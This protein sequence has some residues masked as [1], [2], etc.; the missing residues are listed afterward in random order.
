MH[1][2]EEIAK[3]L[4]VAPCP[5]CGRKNPDDARFCGGC[6]AAR[7]PEFQTGPGV[8]LATDVVADPLLGR[9]IAD[10]YR[11]HALL[12]RG[13]M[14]VV[15]KVE[16]IHI[17]KLMAMKLLHGEL[18]R[19]ATTLKRFRREA[20]AASRLSHPNTVQV[21]D[22]GRS[23]GLVYLV[24]EL[25]E[26]DDWGALLRRHG[27]M[28]F[29][30]VARLV[31]QICGSVQAAHDAGI[32]HRDLKPEN[33]MITQ[34]AEGERA[35]VLDFG[36]AKL[37]D[38]NLGQ[39]VT[40][41]GAIVGTPYYMS[42]E[43]IRGDEVDARGDVYALG[44]IIYRAVT[45]VPPFT[46][47][48]PIA[49]L[50]KHITEDVV[51]PSRRSPRPMPDVVDEICLKA[52]EKDADDRYQSA[53]ALRQAL[54]D[55][56]ASQG[57]TIDPSYRSGVA[58][59]AL[60]SRAATREDVDSFEGRLR[61]KSRVLTALGLLAMLACVIAAYNAYRRWSDAPRVKTVEHEPND[62]IATAHVLPPDVWVWA[63]LGRRR[64]RSEGDIDVFALERPRA[65]A[66]I[67][68]RLEPLPN[69]DMMVELFRVGDSTPVLTLDAGG[70]GEVESVAAFP[71]GEDDYVLQVRE[72][73]RDGVM[74]IENISDRYRIR[75]SRV[76]LSSSSEVEVN[77]GFERATPILVGAPREGVIG[78]VSDRDT[79]CVE[80][81]APT[82][83]VTVALSAVPSL[84]LALVVM[85]RAND[86]R[87]E[88]DE[89]FEGEGET[90][91]VPVIAPMLTCFEVARSTRVGGA[92]AD[93][94]ARYRLLLVPDVRP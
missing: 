90:T 62:D 59:P 54:G 80:A 50:T 33:V 31:A 29:S 7:R 43:Q 70:V 87:R 86:T 57:E 8:E 21:F 53:S 65:A 94:S 79:Y 15:Y 38:T 63:A 10:R 55:Y 88:V 68:V 58:L 17:G 11:I 81:G 37:R 82:G 12:G 20:E 49:V 6:G 52:L 85:D 34:T 66:Q 92:Q 25:V 89:R 74:P 48:S 67:A 36:L 61:R 69:V 40:R 39:T 30:R 93:S 44:A 22:F 72:H 19:D 16:H 84:D 73:W 45:G 51:P 27:P 42:P 77:D 28:D 75:F 56:L 3:T 14:G 18:A 5:L 47:D 91:Q 26:G 24:M 2:G 71:V 23:E 9:V 78:W 64:N 35:K 76:V 1:A 41:A 4:N 83:G 60:K 32:V 46:A 13:G